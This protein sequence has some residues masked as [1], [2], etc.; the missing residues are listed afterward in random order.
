MIWP[1]VTPWSVSPVAL[2]PWQAP[3]T[4]PKA[5]PLDAAVEA[6]PVADEEADDAGV[7]L[8]AR[9]LVVPARL[10]PAASTAATATA[11]RALMAVLTGFLLGDG[12]RLVTSRLWHAFF[13]MRMLLPRCA[14]QDFASAAAD[15]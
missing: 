14:N 1:E 10:Q 9:E 3:V 7:E 2:P 4:V 11:A 5:G 8:E 13:Q 6:D 15:G 12:P